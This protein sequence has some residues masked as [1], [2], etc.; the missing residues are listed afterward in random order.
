MAQAATTRAKAEAEA[1]EVPKTSWRAPP[2]HAPRGLRSVCLFFLKPEQQQL[3]LFC[4]A[5]PKLKKGVVS[6]KRFPLNF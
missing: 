6:T 4:S 3:P 5:T 2:T 1:E